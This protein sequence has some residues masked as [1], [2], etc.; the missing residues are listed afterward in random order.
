M[1]YVPVL[2]AANCIV[3]AVF[4]APHAD[5]PR[6]LIGLTVGTELAGTP[7][8]MENLWP[9]IATYMFGHAGLV[10]LA[11]NMA[12]LLMVGWG[13]ERRAGAR[14]ILYYA[15]GG[16]AGA[17]AHM[18][19]HAMSG[20]DIPLIG[21]SAAVSA[22]VGAAVFHRTI[23]F[24]T[25][26]YFVIV[27][28]VLPWVGE[29]AGFFESTGVSHVSHIGGAVMGGILG[30]GFAAA[31][32]INGWRLRRAANGGAPERQPEGRQAEYHR[33]PVGNAQP[34]AGGRQYDRP[35]YQEL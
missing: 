16:A 7:V 4:A 29:T 21:A 1:R 3:F 27:V 34:R 35:N 5:D 13:L 10:H 32:R 22:L 18:T 19:Y 11:T 26:A 15:A 8:S 20:N 12:M 6:A 25:I 14:V 17:L 30:C 31:G 23:G 28:N 9:G 33:T 24:G 2:L